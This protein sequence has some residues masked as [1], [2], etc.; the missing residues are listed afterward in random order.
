VADDPVP[1]DPKPVAALRRKVAQNMSNTD[2][3]ATVKQGWIQTG[4]ILLGVV[5]STLLAYS[6]LDAKADTALDRASRAETK[7]ERVEADMAT[8]R[9]ELVKIRTV[10][11]ERLPR[12]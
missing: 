12:K 11:E 2:E 7:A 1:E 10:L 9:E 5:V 8:A 6:K 4:V 3:K